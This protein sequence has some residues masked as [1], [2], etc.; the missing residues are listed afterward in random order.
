MPAPGQA[1]SGAA[2]QKNQALLPSPE[3]SERLPP[4]R[5]CVFQ[6]IEFPQAVGVQIEHRIMVAARQEKDQVIV[7][8]IVS[9]TGKHNLPFTTAMEV[10]KRTTWIQFVRLSHFPS[11]AE[12]LHDWIILGAA[13]AAIES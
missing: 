9:D 4:F 11:V 5:W 6:A 8:L 12:L 10:I 2:S 3:F 7:L 1:A 13:L